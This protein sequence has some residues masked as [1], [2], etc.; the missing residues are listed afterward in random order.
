MIDTHQE[1]CLL[2]QAAKIN[3]SFFFDSPLTIRL[4]SVSSGKHAFAVPCSLS[5]R[6]AVLLSSALGER[7]PAFDFL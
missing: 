7:I 3:L 4:T 6:S 2:V 1:L 5:C